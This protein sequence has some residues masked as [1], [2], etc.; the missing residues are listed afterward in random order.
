MNW[1]RYEHGFKSIHQG[2]AFTFI[3]FIWSFIYLQTWLA[4]SFGAVFAMLAFQNVYFS[5]VGKGLIV[6]FK[7]KQKRI[8]IDGEEELIMEFDNGIVPIWNGTLTL[9]IEDPVA[10]STD[11]RKHYSGVYD[12]SVPFAVGSNKKVEIRIPLEGKKRGMSRVTRLILEVPHLFGDGSVNMELEDPISYQ[13]LVYPRVTALGRELDSS[14]FKPG[15][16]EQKTSLFTDALQMIGTRDYVPTDRFDQIH[17]TASAKMQKLQ[18]KE[19][20]PV[21]SQS[22]ALILNTIEKDRGYMDFETKVE[23]LVSYADY[24]MKHNIPYSVSINLRTFGATPYLQLPSGQGKVQFQKTMVMLAKISEKNAKMRYEDMLL[25]MESTG[26]L[27]QTIVLIS[28]ENDKI[29]AVAQKWSRQYAVIMDTVSEGSGN[30]WD[31]PVLKK[32]GTDSA[33]PSA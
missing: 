7:A 32:T 22:V 5:K 25:N 10:P 8:L 29:R 15:E 4:A 11:N 16:V 1:I 17:W 14:P 28:H 2:M 19:F 24:C 31:N 18:T 30:E 26:Q 3:F 9:S 21:S 12:L 6:N 23:R 20:L 27:P 33:F 13:S